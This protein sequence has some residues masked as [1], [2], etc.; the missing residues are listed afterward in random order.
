MNLSFGLLS[1]LIHFR[2]GEFLRLGL[3]AQ[4]VPI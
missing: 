1:N 2:P 3:V 4:N